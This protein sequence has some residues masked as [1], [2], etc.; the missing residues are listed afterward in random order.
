[1]KAIF[2]IQLFLL[3][4]FFVSGCLEFRFND[5]P[6]ATA[7][8][9]TPIHWDDYTTVTDIRINNYDIEVSQPFVPS[10]KSMFDGLVQQTNMTFGSG[11]WIP[12]RFLNPDESGWVRLNFEPQQDVIVD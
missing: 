9:N 8:G 6:Y 2:K 1:M 11:N 4:S 12:T 10:V 7:S 5:R 3:I